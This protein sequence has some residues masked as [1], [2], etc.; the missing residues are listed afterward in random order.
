MGGCDDDGL[1]ESYGS[2]INGTYA[3]EMFSG[4]KHYSLTL[5]RSVGHRSYRGPSLAGRGEAIYQKP[6]NRCAQLAQFAT[7][8][9]IAIYLVATKEEPN[10]EKK[11]LFVGIGGPCRHALR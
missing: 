6:C 2:A 3:L 1:D 10:D 9:P 7:T 5:V 8:L 4:W 11:S